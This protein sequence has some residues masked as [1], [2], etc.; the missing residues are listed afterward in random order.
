[1]RGVRFRLPDMVLRVAIRV[2]VAETFDQEGN[3]MKL[4]RVILLLIS[5]I[6]LLSFYVP[7]QQEPNEPTEIHENVELI[8]LPIPAAIPDELKG[9]Y[10]RF[11]PIFEEVIEESTA[12]QP[13]DSAVTISVVAGTKEIGSRKIQRVTAEITAYRKNAKHKYV[14]TLLLHS[15]ATG[16]AVNKEEITEFLKRHILDPV[17]EIRHLSS[18]DLP[19]SFHQLVS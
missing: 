11:L 17:K 8:A 3:I 2:A 16:E 12:D 19:S 4:L 13:P 9:E 18:Q 1:V 14:A 7:A 15:Y 6:F 5:A 10:Q